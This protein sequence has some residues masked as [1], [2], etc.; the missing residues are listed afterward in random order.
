MIKS[1]LD[2]VCVSRSAL[3]VVALGG[4]ASNDSGQGAAG[5]VFG[6]LQAAL[7]A[8]EECVVACP[9]DHPQVS[10]VG[11]TC[12]IG[13]GLDDGAS[14]VVMTEGL[15]LCPGTYVLTDQLLVGDGSVG[16]AGAGTELGLHA[17]VTI[18]G[19]EGTFISVQRG[20]RLVAEGSSAQPVVFTSAQPEAERAAGDWG[21]LV[22]NGR[23]TINVAGGEAVGEAGTGT[24]GGD[25]DEDSSGVLRFVRVEFA[26]FA[27]DEENELNGIAFQGVGRGTIVDHVAVHQT[28]DDGVE[29]FGG[30]VGVNHVTISGAGDDSIDWTQ[31]WRGTA[32]TVTVLQSVAGS[33]AAGQHGIEADG[34]GEDPTAQPFSSPT[35]R[36]LTL[37]GGGAAGSFGALLRLGTRATLVDSVI[38]GFPVCL[39]VDG[40][41][42]TAAALDG[43]IVLNNVTLNCDVPA[44]ETDVGAQAL[45]AQPGVFVIGSVPP[46]AAP[47]AL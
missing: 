21:G 10:Q 22:L 20:S 16:D 12:L 40:D 6:E 17:G 47:E 24:Y 42:S 9:V 39:A 36:N 26:G 34:Q 23:A 29:F 32:D 37:V 28:T 19:N 30:T 44:L 35:L 3:F 8:P 5:A 43:E 2:L 11:D 25:D 7:V 27:V 45:L 1:G 15:E 13:D 41:E 33:A 38:S 18:L 14:P 31:G 4:C 46:V